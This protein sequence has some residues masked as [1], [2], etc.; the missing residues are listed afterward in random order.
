MVAVIGEPGVGKT[1]LVYEFIRSHHTH[2][3]LVLESSSVSYG[4][5]TAYLPVRDLLKADFQLD[6]RDDG[7]KM[8]EKLTGK[9]LTLDATLGPTLPAFLALIDVPVEDRQWQ[10][11][12]PTQRRQR[13]DFHHKLSAR[14]VGQ[15]SAIFTEYLRVANMS[16]RPKPKPGTQPREYLP[17]GATAKAGLNKAILDGAPSCLSQYAAVQSGRSWCRVC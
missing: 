4:K 1:R 2:N 17:N 9:L 6:D 3:W 10:A 7:R 16:R 12:D 5:A 8:R 11:L 13:K 14:L 15:A